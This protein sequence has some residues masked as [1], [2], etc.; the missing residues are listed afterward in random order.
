MSRDVEFDEEQTWDWKN[1]D[2]LKQIALDEE[3]GQKNETLR[4]IQ[5]ALSPRQVGIQ[6]DS[7]GS[8]SSIM[9]KTKSIQE[10]Y[11]SSRAVDVNFDE[12][13]NNLCLFAGFDPLTYEEASKE[14][15]W[16]KAMEEEIHAIKKNN[17]WELT[18][19]PRGH[20]AIGVKW[21]FKTKRNAKGEV[22]RH[23]ARLVVKGYKQKYGVDYEEVFAPMD[24]KSA[25]LNG[26]LEEEVYVEQPPGFVVAGQ[27]EKVYRLKKALYRLKQ[28]PRAWNSRIDAYFIREGFV[29]C[30]YEH[31]LYVKVNSGEDM[32]LVCLYVDDLIFTG[33][34]SFMAREFKQSMEKEFEMIDYGMIRYFLSI[35]VQQ[36]EDGV[37]ISQERYAKEILKKFSMENCLPVDTPVE[38]GIRLTKEEEGKPM[39]PTYYKSLV[40]CLRY[41]TCSRP[42]MLFGVG[43]V[44]RFMETPKTSHLKAA[45]RSLRYVKGTV[46]YG[47]LYSSKGGMELI[48]FGDSDWAGS[49]DD[50]KST[51]GIDLPRQG[52]K[53]VTQR[54]T[55]VTFTDP[56]ISARIPKLRHSIPVDSMNTSK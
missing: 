40:G 21:V 55:R 47:L 20:K 14:T 10:I 49:C 15:K 35:E 39:N 31:S 45:K 37:F 27:E 22:E 42:N 16:R 53:E 3:Y 1:N 9:R 19:L 8:S 28:A 6:F 36:G 23:K 17:T 11:D 43:L 2:Q 24:V 26:N 52:V 48:G 54:T 25:F 50:R 18:L 32:L 33:N 46:D 7:D 12:E 44:S 56:L 4:D 30:P 51:T 29:K 13:F 34:S 5:K 38:C 41:L